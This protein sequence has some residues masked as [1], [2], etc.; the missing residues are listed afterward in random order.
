[1]DKVLLASVLLA[2]VTLPA[3][4]S[5]DPSPR[6]GL[7]RALWAVAVFNVVYLAFLLISHPRPAYV[8]RGG[9]IH[10]ELLRPGPGQPGPAR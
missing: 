3:L 9:I 1:M 7:R 6:R 4:F 2:T 8:P 5:G 10:D